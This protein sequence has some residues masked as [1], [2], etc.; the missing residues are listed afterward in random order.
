MRERAGLYDSDSDD[1]PEMEEIRE[2]ARKSVLNQLR[3]RLHQASASTLQWRLW[4][5][6]HW[7]EWNRSEMDCKPILE[8]F[9]LFPLISM[10]AVPIVSSQHWLDVDADPWCKRVLKVYLHQELVFT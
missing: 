10:R 6:S 9:Y 4:H 7:K 1:D 2:T 5:S 8:W 3:V